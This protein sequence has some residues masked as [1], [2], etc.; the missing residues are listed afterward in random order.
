MKTLA[1]LMNMRGRVVAITGGAGHIGAAAAEALAE[2]GA[3]IA[4]IDRDAAGATRVA[5]DLRSRFDVPAGV[6]AADLEHEAETAALPARIVAELGRLDVLVNNAAFVGDTNLQ[7]WTVPFEQQSAATWRRAVEVNLT[8]CFVLSQ[9]A[10]PALRDTPAGAILNISSIYGVSGPDMRLYE[11]TGMGQPAAYAASK[12][13]L[14]Q[15]TRW[16]STALAPDIRVNGIVP[17]GVWRNQPAP[18]VEKY[19]SRTPLGRMAR[20]EDFKGAV[21]YLASDLSAYVTG[22]NLVVD[23]GW[24]AW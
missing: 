21:A 5:D 10:V 16:L 23:G 6:F 20:E 4:L 22:H 2:L 7:G 18:F 17:G 24:T 15:M 9:A 11:G 14:V 19:E 12:G 8:A 13:G 3:G 1:E